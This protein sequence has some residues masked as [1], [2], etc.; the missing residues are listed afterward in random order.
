MSNKHLEISEQTYNNFSKLKKIA[1][2][3]QV[4]MPPVPTKEQERERVLYYLD[5][6]NV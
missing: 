6:C 4:E 5:F 3:S 2:L 1:A